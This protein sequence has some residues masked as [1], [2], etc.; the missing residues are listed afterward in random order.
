MWHKSMIIGLWQLTNDTEWMSSALESFKELC[1]QELSRNG[2]LSAAVAEEI[3]AVA[4][5]NECNEPNGNCTNG[6]WHRKHC[7]AFTTAIL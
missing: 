4:C 2:S 7:I 1:M 6:K 3:V 5:P